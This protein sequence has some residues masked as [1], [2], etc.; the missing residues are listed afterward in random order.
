MTTTDILSIAVLDNGD[1]LFLFSNGQTDGATEIEQNVTD[2]NGGTRILGSAA[3]GRRLKRLIMQ[4]TD[5][6]ILST[7]SIRDSTGG[8][9]VNLVSGERTV[10]GHNNLANLD[11]E[12][13]IYITRSHTIYAATAD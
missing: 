13:D 9:I 11:A 8:K 5:G 2:D 10:T 3:E 1:R 6:S 4:A 7:V 12:C